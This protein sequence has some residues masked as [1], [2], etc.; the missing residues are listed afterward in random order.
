MPNFGAEATGEFVKPDGVCLDVDLYGVVWTVSLGVQQMRRQAKDGEGWRGKSRF[1]LLSLR[2][3]AGLVFLYF[4]F[5]P[6]FLTF[7]SFQGALTMV[8]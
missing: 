3:S 5:Q 8:C 4:G 1:C 7:L 2:F 6:F